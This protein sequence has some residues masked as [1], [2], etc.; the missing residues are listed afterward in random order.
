LRSRCCAAAF[1]SRTREV[2]GVNLKDID[3]LQFAALKVAA[4]AK[5]C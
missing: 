5:S 2:R 4:E 3:V 1:D